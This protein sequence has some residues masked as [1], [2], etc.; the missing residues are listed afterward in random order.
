MQRN[1]QK[2]QRLTI[3]SGDSQASLPRHFQD[4]RECN[5]QR[6]RDI[7]LR[8]VDGKRPPNVLMRVGSSKRSSPALEEMP[9]LDVVAV[10]SPYHVQAWAG[11]RQ[12]NLRGLE[13]RATYDSLPRSFTQRL[14]HHNDTMFPQRT[15]LRASQRFS[16]QLRSPA[17]RTP[18]QRR[19][20]STESSGFVGAEDNAF[21]RERKAVKDHAA[22]TSGALYGGTE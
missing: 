2:Y 19:F 11:T 12:W 9:Q 21:N 13:L 1:L 4:P 20:A 3:P 14:N 18:F 10:T 15:M 5:H 17:V 22:A 6:E 7:S 16:S 8:S